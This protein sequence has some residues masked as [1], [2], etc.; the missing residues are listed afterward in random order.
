MLPVD[1][2]GVVFL[3]FLVSC[4]G[5]LI[6]VSAGGSAAEE[7]LPRTVVAGRDLLACFDDQRIVGERLGWSELTY[8]R[9]IQSKCAPEAHVFSAAYSEMLGREISGAGA[10]Q[11][12]RKVEQAVR[13]AILDAALDYGRAAVFRLH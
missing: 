1:C 6:L 10:R 3:R 4:T 13:G 12:A 7:T 5:L 11:K 2:E 8:Y 9:A